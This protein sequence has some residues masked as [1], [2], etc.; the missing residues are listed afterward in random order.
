MLHSLPTS[1]CPIGKDRKNQHGGVI[2]SSTRTSCF[3]YLQNLVLSQDM[4]GCLWA[5]SA[6]FGGHKWGTFKMVQE[7]WGMRA[8]KLS[9]NIYVWNV[10]HYHYG[11]DAFDGARWA[12]AMPILAQ[13]YFGPSFFYGTL[14]N[15]PVHSLAM[16]WIR[17]L[18][19]FRL[20]DSWHQQID[21]S[22]QRQHQQQIFVVGLVS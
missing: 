13:R 11:H 15:P 3:Q 8:A 14:P 4:F 2:C 19:F 20:H 17:R 5:S 7:C 1:I 10:S 21:P 6:G 18:I 16:Q 12:G 22:K 9:L